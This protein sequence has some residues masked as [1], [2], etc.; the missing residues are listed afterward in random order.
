[1]NKLGQRSGVVSELSN[2]LLNEETVPS[3][4]EGSSS[5]FELDDGCERASERREEREVRKG[6]SSARMERALCDEEEEKR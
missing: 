4:V 3:R 2:R 1:M 6:E 5:P